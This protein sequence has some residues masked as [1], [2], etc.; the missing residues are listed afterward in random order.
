MP[1]KFSKSSLLQGTVGWGAFGSGKVRPPSNS[2]DALV[3][4]A[5]FGRVGF[6]A[7]TGLIGL[8]GFGGWWTSTAIVSKLGGLRRARTFCVV[9]LCS[10]S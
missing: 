7:G 6:G 5:W 3:R 8:M 2:P 4:G 1:V 9:S 10:F